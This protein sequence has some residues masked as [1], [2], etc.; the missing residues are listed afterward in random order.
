M[1]VT[2]KNGKLIPSP[3]YRIRFLISLRIW[4]QTVPFWIADRLPWFARKP[5][6]NF[7]ADREVLHNF[8]LTDRALSGDTFISSGWTVCIKW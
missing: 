7:L 8:L 5:I 1:K 3:W 6:V 2:V 4:P